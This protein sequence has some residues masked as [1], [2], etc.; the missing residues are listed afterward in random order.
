[1]PAIG[2]MLMITTKT[3]GNSEND[4]PTQLMMRSRRIWMHKGVIDPDFGALH[5]LS[6]DP[7]VYVELFLK[8]AR[9]QDALAYW[10]QARRFA[11][12]SSGLGPD[13]A[14]LTLYYSFLNAAKALLSYKAVMPARI[15]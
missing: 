10:L 7:W 6:N 14:P 9:A 11:D 1:M 15:M 12:A 4:V 5:V 3:N 13:A 8:R 2:D